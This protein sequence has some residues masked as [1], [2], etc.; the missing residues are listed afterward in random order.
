MQKDKESREDSFG[1]LD[2]GSF[3]FLSGS[4]KSLSW[5]AY[6]VLF[7]LSLAFFSPG[8]STIPPVDRDE[9]RFAQA[10][11]QM[12]ESGNY[13][14]IRF[15]SEARYKKPIGIYW[16]QA[17][18]VKLF[19]PGKLNNIWAYRLPSLIGAALAVVL[20]AAVGS[21][22]FGPLAGFVAALLMASCLL[23]NVEARM[24]KTDAVLLACVLAAQYT[25]AR[26]YLG[27]AGRYSFFMFWVAQA[28]GFLIKGPVLLLITLATLLYLRI[29]EKKIGW[30]A[31]LKPRIGV[32]FALLLAAPWFAAITLQSGGAFISES[33]GHDL[34]AKIWQGQDRGIVPPG[35]HLL[36]FPLLFFPGS[37]LAL[38]SIPGIIRSKQDSAVRF[39]LGWLLVPWL[40]FELSLT[41]LPHYVLPL[42]PAIAILAAVTSLRGFPEIYEKRWRWFGAAAT[43]LWLAAGITVAAAI[44]FLPWLSDGKGQSASVMAGLILLAMMGAMIVFI[45]YRRAKA[46]KAMVF[47]NLLF[48]LMAFG[49]VIPSLRSVWIS[50]Q[51]VQVA[52]NIK[53][54]QQLKIVSA[55]YNEPSLV[56][57]AGTDTVFTEYGEGVAD[58]MREDPCVLGLLDAGHERA[59]LDK[60]GNSSDKPFALARFYG[61]NLGKW[62]SVTLAL[63]R[64]YAT[65]PAG[66]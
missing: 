32:P 35:L 11:K 24:A 59:F 5:R 9:P 54:C 41:K 30:F 4:G 53:P 15:Q 51:M 47:C 57:L 25:L 1:G 63:Y 62:N 18:S 43:G 65:D 10:T 45:N 12:I 6:I 38:F 48:V 8:I 27:K 64:I 26:A 17:A 52:E 28:A 44:T 61:P 19:S 49:L 40:V 2:A 34:M 33:A 66:K 37:L 20:T 60:F 16:L 46:V 22:F 50:R 56:F 42:Y 39:F 21:L 31:A 14:D 55:S 36:A 7:L 3:T 58:R 13:I 29:T 23:L